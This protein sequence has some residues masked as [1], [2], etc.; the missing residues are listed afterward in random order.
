MRRLIEL[1]WE[2]F[3]QW[4]RERLNIESPSKIWPLCSFEN[5]IDGILFDESWW[6]DVRNFD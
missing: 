5:T 4:L 1:L 6:K 3:K 2:T